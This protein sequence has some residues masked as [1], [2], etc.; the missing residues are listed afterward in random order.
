MI[1]GLRIQAVP[2][3]GGR[4]VRPE[5]FGATV[6]FARPEM[7]VLVDRAFARRLGVRSFPAPRPGDP[8]GGL[9]PATP[10]EAHLTVSAHCRAG[11]EGC[12]IDA[13]PDRLAPLDL[14][15]WT[16]VLDRL[17]AAGVYHL[18]MGGGEDGDWGLLLAL[19]ERARARGMTPNLTTAGRDLTP[20]LA[21][22]LAIFERVHLSLDG[23]GERQAAIRGRDDF[24]RALMSLRILRAYHPK[25]GVNC[26]VGRPNA[27]HLGDLFAL[28]DAEGVRQVELLR[29]KPVGRGAARFAELDLSA[30]Q[31]AGLVRR[32]LFLSLRHRIRVRMDCSF[33]PM[34]CATGVPPGQLTR[35]GLAGCVAGS[36][37]VSVGP[38]GAL[39][40]CSFDDRPVGGLDRLGRPGT[41]ED[42]RSWTLRA[43]E[44]CASCRWL[45]ICR[46]GCHVVARHVC[47]DFR[48]PDPGCPYVA[49]GSMTG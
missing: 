46:G 34:V 21:R 20:R 38:D 22:R 7:V 13:R 27:D 42:F 30:R 40:G 36:W 17:A 18:A 25:P 44:P 37:L 35:L 11:C 39:S 10:F 45:A 43:P 28:L 47:G 41:F 26:V 9:D 49:E 24:A 15:A 12:Y 23:V 29:Y 48:A 16:G 6:A 32:V 1:P 14:D 5:P 4:R 2:G 19:A 31:R 3:T 33:T 8:P